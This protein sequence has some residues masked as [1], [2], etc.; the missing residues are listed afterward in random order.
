[1]WLLARRGFYLPGTKTKFRNRFSTHQVPRE[2]FLRSTYPSLTFPSQNL[3]DFII[4]DFNLWS[5]SPAQVCGLTGRVLTYGEV[6][7]LSRHFGSGL[8]DLGLEVGD[9]IGIVLPNCPEFGPLMLGAVALGVTVVP[10]S[11]MFT[12][13]EMAR[14]FSQAQPKL[15]ITIDSHLETVNNSLVDAPTKP[16][17][18]SITENTKSSALP[19]TQVTSNDGKKFENRP[20]FCLSTTMAVL[21][22]SSGTTGPPKGVMLTHQTLVTNMC[23]YNDPASGNIMTK[24]IPGTKQEARISII[25]VFHIFGLTVNILQALIM[26]IKMVMMPKFEPKSFI[27][28]LEKYKP[29]VM[30]IVPPLVSFIAQ[31]PAI[32][33]DNHLSNMYSIGSG[34]APLSPH[35]R[36]LLKKK[37]APKEIAIREAYGMTECPLITRPPAVPKE[38]SIGKLLN[39][40][41]AKVVNLETGECCGPGEE[42]ELYIKGPNVMSGYYNNEE[43]T[44]EVFKDGWFHTGDVVCYDS[45]GW[46]YIVDRIKDMMK[47]KGYQVS[48]SELEDVIREVPGVLDVAIIGVHDDRLGE[49]PKA[50][51]VRK[52]VD[53]EADTI[54]SYM[55]DKVAPYKKLAGGIVFLQEL[56]KSPAGK[57]LRKELKTM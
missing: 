52:S 26:G 27:A 1:M 55:E 12:S 50:F 14:L 32:T 11:P 51:I 38:G 44:K 10:V 41:E 15:V 25:P 16:L 30:N 20:D 42:G 56:P 13:S 19:L 3:H 18:V 45:E 43:A 49:A 46:F 23:I 35:I 24:Y 39:N 8:M 53:L 28:A 6:K 37:M 34:G 48:P 47:V 57:V 4:Q 54:H 9:K 5:D 21:P 17:V 29:A 22:F 40:L 2:I 7:Q 31:S 33:R 36:E